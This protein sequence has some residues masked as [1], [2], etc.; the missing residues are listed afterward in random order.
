MKYVVIFFL[1]AIFVS[2]LI[3]FLSRACKREVLNLEL[4]VSP[5]SGIEPLVVRIR[6]SAQSTIEI[7]SIKLDLDG[8]RNYEVDQS[9]GKKSYSFEITHNYIVPP[10]D[11]GFYT[12]YGLVEG[13]QYS[14]EVSETIQ[15]LPRRDFG[16]SLLADVCSG[17]PP[18]EVNFYL[19]IECDECNFQMDCEGDGQFDFSQQT[20]QFVCRFTKE[21][22]YPSKIS[23]S[24]NFGNFENTEFFYCVTES[25]SRISRFIEVFS[26]LAPVRSIPPIQS[27][28]MRV[29]DAFFSDGGTEYISIAGNFGTIILKNRSISDIILEDFASSLNFAKFFKKNDLYLFFSSKYGTFRWSEATRSIEKLSDRSF[30]AL[31]PIANSYIVF[32][33]IKQVYAFCQDEKFESCQEF[34][35]EDIDFFSQAR[36]FVNNSTIYFLLTN[37]LRQDSIKIMQIPDGKIQTYISKEIFPELLG[38]Y[39]YDY[40]RSLTLFV[41][42]P[43][44]L[45]QIFQIVAHNTIQGFLTQDPL[46]IRFNTVS[47]FDDN[48][49]IIGTP[50]FPCDIYGEL[51][52]CNKL[53]FY[54][55]DQRFDRLEGK[56]EITD[57]YS[58]GQKVYLIG[59]NMM[60]IFFPYF[61]IPDSPFGVSWVTLPGKIEDF[62]YE[63]KNLYI[64]SRRALSVFEVSEDRISFKEYFEIPSGT[65]SKVVRAGDKLF[66]AISDD[67]TTPNEKEG[68]IVVIDLKSKILNL[69]SNQ[70]IAESLINCISVYDTRIIICV[71]N[72]ILVLSDY[73]ELLME[74]IFP[75]SEYLKDI[76][77]AGKTIYVI[78]YVKLYTISFDSGKILDSKDTIMQFFKANVDWS[79]KLLF[80]AEGQDHSF[81]IFDISGT[82]P[83]EITRVSIDYGVVNDIASDIFYSNNYLFVSSTYAGLFVFDISDPLRPLIRKKTFFDDFSASLEKCIAGDFIVCLSSGELLFIK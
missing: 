45:S 72:K 32:D 12:I 29:R 39:K 56:G 74:I 26:K 42:I 4:V 75:E 69:V 52:S 9:V 20:T 1:S 38:I 31:Y 19:N 49:V 21:G 5:K 77:V 48:R 46:R 65:P 68:K 76:H 40:S 34:P 78:S 57:S 83:N 8:D 50:E 36:Y 30:I 79:K 73:G 6:M 41:L 11:S 82:L 54:I 7:K 3:I 55:K 15:V 28:V 2:I 33:H 25:Q 10:G 18:L 13:E 66:V 17:S 44:P 67:L 61:S 60:E 51:K 24:D 14:K 53:I 62:F 16:F 37:S 27:N 59:E 63:N 22:L 64:L 35:L 23:I 80:T 47:I 43:Q 70:Q 81:R 71:R 58:D